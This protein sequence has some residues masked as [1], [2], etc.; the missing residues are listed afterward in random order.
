M[1]PG[2]FVIL[3]AGITLISVL[4]AMFYTDGSATIVRVSQGGHP[5][6]DLPAWQEK[7]VSVAGPLGETVIE[8]R[9]GRARIV[10]SPCT[11]KICI[12]AGWLDT[13]GETTAC[14]PNRVSVALLGDDPRFDALNF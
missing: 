7:R 10:A 8:I 9:E 12:R 2:D 5:H 11:K 1:R 3:L 13:A 14:V 6:E 4:G